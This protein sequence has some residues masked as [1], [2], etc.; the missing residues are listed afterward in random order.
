VT[1]NGCGLV[2]GRNAYLINDGNVTI[3]EK[4]DK[5]AEPSLLIGGRLIN[6]SKVTNN[7]SIGYTTACMYK[8]Q[9]AY[10]LD[11]GFSGKKWTGKGRELL[12]YMIDLRGP[13]Y[14]E[15]YKCYVASGKTVLVDGSVYVGSEQHETVF[16]PVDSKVKLTVKV[17]GFSDKT[18]EFTTAKSASDYVNAAYKNI[19]S[20]SDPNNYIKVSLSK[21]KGTADSSVSERPLDIGDQIILGNMYYSVT[22]ADLK[23]GTVCFEHGNENEKSLTIPDTIKYQ[24]RTYKVT[25]V[26]YCGTSVE[27][28]TVGK[29]VEYLDESAF[30]YC[31]K[32]KS[33]NIKTKLLENESVGKGAFD[34]V[35][36]SCVIT[37][38]KKKLKAYKKLFQAAGLNSKVKVKGK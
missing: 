18:V 13:E 16:L 26:N 37:V 29:N 11:N 19:K 36:S 2:I 32:L 8:E 33:I 34:K 23:G 10:A 6:N 31:D 1:D 5:S 38:P 35:P 9:K 28:V 21:G 25:M 27:S 12:G 3:K 14:Y 20:G 30:Q 24:G 7:G 15:E 17:S 4:D 22:T